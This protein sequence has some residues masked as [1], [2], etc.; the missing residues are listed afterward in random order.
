MPAL[1]EDPPKTYCTTVSS[2]RL[3]KAN[4]DDDYYPFFDDKVVYP[5][6]VLH[7]NQY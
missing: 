6:Q 1:D 7:R 4:G 2:G 5:R 3:Y